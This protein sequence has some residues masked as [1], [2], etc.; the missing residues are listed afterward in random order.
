[1]FGYFGTQ[2]D[3]SG[4]IKRREA[5]LPPTGKPVGFRVKN[6]MTYYIQMEDLAANALIEALRI[7]N[8]T[9]FLSYHDIE[10]YGAQVVEILGRE[11]HNAILILSRDQTNIF[12]H[13]YSDFFERDEK[14]GAPGVRLKAGKTRNNLIDAFRGYWPLTSSRRSLIKLP[15]KPC[16]KQ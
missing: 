16:A 10:T 5:A 11:N 14:N 8:D 15:L 4:R 9:D 3:G 2:T 6:F 7:K 1:M 13:D 12:F